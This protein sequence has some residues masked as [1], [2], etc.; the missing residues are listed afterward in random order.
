M[1]HCK[2]LDLL[3]FTKPHQM[4]WLFSYCHLDNAKTVW[5]HEIDAYK[6]S[7]TTHS[8]CFERRVR[9]KS[10]LIL[11]GVQNLIIAARL[12][13]TA[14]NIF[15][16]FGWN[17]LFQIF[18]AF[19]IHCLPRTKYKKTKYNINKWEISSSVHHAI[20]VQ[21]YLKQKVPHKS[22]DLKFA[23]WLRIPLT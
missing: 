18:P 22:L 17:I 21:M 4:S 13:D 19:C 9:M 10:R 7:L 23:Y 6:E 5:R 12:W 11:T 1:P 3:D 14:V 20:A 16:I 2:K 8:V 15:Q